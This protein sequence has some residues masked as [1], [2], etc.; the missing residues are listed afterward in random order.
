MLMGT[1]LIHSIDILAVNCSHLLL[2]HSLVTEMFA[3]VE[4]IFAA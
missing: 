1:G 4:E 2:P 3:D